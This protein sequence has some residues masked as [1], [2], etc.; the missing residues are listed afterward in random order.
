MRTLI[1][2][3]HILHH[4][5]AV[6]AFGHISVRSPIDPTQYIIPAYLPP[7]LVSSPSDLI[8]YH[9]AN[10]TPID[11]AAPKGYSERFIHGEIYAQYPSVQCVVHAHAQAVLPYAVGEEKLKAV[12]HM[13]GFLGTEVRVWDIAPV[14]EE[15]NDG[16]A[17]QQD[18][19]VNNGVL[20]KAL[21]SEFAGGN[22]EASEVL[23][24]VV[25]MKR[26]G[27]TVVAEDV[28]TAVFRAIYTIVNAGVQT[29]AMGMQEVVPGLNERQ[30]DDCRKMNEATQDKAWMLW[31]REVQNLPL[32]TND[33]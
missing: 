28:P 7:A 16:G 26:H 27:Y 30:A 25:L 2:A 8:T 19:L 33:A 4:H 22:T 5:S 24:P 12:V 17:H 1:T 32:Y 23:E 14:Y 20:G 29:E 10:S 15:L 21:A 11:P 9:V 6:D 18:M 31:A 3:N 13:A